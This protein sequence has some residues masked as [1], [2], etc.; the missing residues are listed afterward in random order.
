MMVNRNH[1]WEVGQ[2]VPLEL[3]RDVVGIPISPVWHALIAPPTRESIARAHLRKKGVFA[4]YPEHKRCYSRRGKQIERKY[5]TISRIIYARFRAQPNWDVMLDR[6]II[7]GFFQHVGGEPVAI[8]S[9]DIRILQGLESTAERLAREREEAQRVYPGDRAI[10]IRGALSGRPV[11][12]DAVS[13]DTA[14]CT[15]IESGLPIVAERKTLSKQ[16]A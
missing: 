4:F 14:H 5:P 9:D 2:T 8:R 1:T 12:V 15:D 16:E 10:I 7:T 6:R 3:G 13:G 11:I